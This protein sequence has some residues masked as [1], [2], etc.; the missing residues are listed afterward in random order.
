MRGKLKR[1]A[2]KLINRRIVPEEVHVL[3]SLPRGTDLFWDFNEYL[4]ELEVKL[5]FDVGAHVG[6]SARGYLQNFPEASIYCFEPASESFNELDSRYSDEARVKCFNLA[7]GSE[8]KK[9]ELLV[10]GPSARYSVD[11][12][13]AEENTEREEIRIDTIDD[14]CTRHEISHIDFLQI[15]TEGYDLQVLY[16]ASEMLSNQQIGAIQVE[17]SMNARNADHVPFHRF[18]SYLE[19]INYRTFAIY[20]QFHE[21]PSG[22]PN[23]RRTNP[24]FIS[25][26]TI[27]R[28]RQAGRDI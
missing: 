16:G 17:T 7:M 28:N 4:P 2:E 14:F 12:G 13:Q 18:Q 8:K 9:G 3:S 25:E 6:H 10:E 21:W 15:D 23:L 5:V 24:V 22:R 20:E 26:K 11:E 27:E 1:L 19:Q